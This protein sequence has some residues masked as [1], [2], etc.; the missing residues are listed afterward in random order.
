MRARRPK[1]PIAG[2]PGAANGP[3]IKQ[4]IATIGAC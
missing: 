2:S 3:V 1:T 4:F